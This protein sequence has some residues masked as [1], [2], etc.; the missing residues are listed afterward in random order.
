MIPKAGREVTCRESRRNGKI[1]REGK[2]SMRKRVVPWKK[3]KSVRKKDEK[4]QST[5][6]G[7]SGP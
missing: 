1:H 6:K 5:K 4:K 3:R 2:R 7:K